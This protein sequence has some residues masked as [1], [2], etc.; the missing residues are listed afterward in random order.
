[1]RN[2]NRVHLIACGVPA[3]DLE[4]VAADLQLDMSTE[5]LPGG[6]HNRPHELRR[7]LQEAIDRASVRQGLDRIAIGYGLCGMGTVGIHARHVP[8]AIPLVNDCIAL[9]LGSDAAYREQFAQY[10][11]T[12]YITPG[13]IDEKARPS[14]DTE[15]SGV[16]GPTEYDFDE[17]VEKYGREN[18]EAIR[19]FLESWRRN[20]QRAAYIRTGARPDDGGAAD[21]ARAM[22]QEFGWA[23]EELEGTRTLLEKLLTQDVSSDEVLIVPPHHVTAYN[24]VSESLTAAPVWEQKAERSG[25]DVLVFE[26]DRAENNGPPLHLGLGIDA[27][28]TYTDVVLY[29]FDCHDV[30]QKAKALTTRWDYTVGIEAALDQ[31][32]DRLLHRVNLVA[33]ST[34][35]A[36]NAVV[37]GA[38]QE[39]GLLIMPPYGLFQPDDIRYRPLAVLSGRLDIDGSELEPI[40]PDEVRRTVREMIDR[41]NVEAFAVTG[42]ASHANP[43]HELQVR[44][45]IR[46]V[47]GRSVTCG[48]EVSEMLNYRV[49]ATTAALNARIIP[50]L[51]ALIEHVG[52]SLE[53]RG[54]AA[55]R[56]V[57]KSDG[58][59][60]NAGEALRRPI[61]TVLSGPAAS[62]A[63]ACHLCRLSDATII[64][65]GGTTTDT[66]LIRDGSVRTCEQ[67]ATIGGRR[68][69][70]RALDFRTLGLGGDSRIEVRGGELH[71]GPQ[72]VAPIS[73]LA[74]QGGLRL[75]VFDWIEHH[76][77][78]FGDT[79]RGMEFIA[80]AGRAD[81]RNER[82]RQVVEALADGPLSADELAHRLD[83]GSWELLPLASLAARNI[84]QR[85]GLTPTDLLHAVGRLELWDRRAALRMAELVGRLIGESSDTLARRVFDR[86]SRMLAVEILKRQL[87]EEVD[88]EG[89]DASPVAAALVDNLLSGG[90]S[91]YRVRVQLG[92]PLV[93]VGAPVDF[94]LPRAAEFFGAEAI[95]PPDA[96]VANA[97]G[98]ITSRVHVGQRVRIVPTDDGRYAVSGAPDAPAFPD[99]ED[100]QEFAL[101]EL[102][103][104]LRGRARRAGTR[105]T[106]VEVRIDDRIAHTA[107]GADLF[108]GRILDASLTGRPDLA[109]ME[110]PD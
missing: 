53:R 29:D 27:G 34:T 69:H 58:S 94:F 56:M 89:L 80:L 90:G 79:S 52:V 37:E 13:W 2:R 16:R 92:R 38:G 65:I 22:A 41:Q 46:D 66:A 8:L 10:P 104:A 39:A 48:H 55:P 43:S 26:G 62:A 30:I 6:L 98:A 95:I 63:G 44:S 12:Y 60:M 20:Y 21:I 35:L 88:P 40:E 18:A 57:V 71:V 93:G 24:A 31:L 33:I 67:G 97:I 109:R 50:C 86:I 70:V 103:R 4:A 108:L 3:A 64:D 82:E 72:R 7:R 91:G 17:L 14:S 51:E 76:F 59:L 15:Q 85:C 11:G 83:V 73:W 84:V 107:S 49:R 96:D 106:R 105:E 47:S 99:F 78:R 74:G 81:G 87:G 32:D 102:Q 28:G 5:S 25:E 77:D 68:T 75:D 23:Y 61:E 1:M 9:F 100:A 45:I 36:T 42:Y 101:A 19:Y 54:I 110:D